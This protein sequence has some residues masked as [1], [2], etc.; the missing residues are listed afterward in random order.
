MKN[1]DRLSKDLMATT[2]E[3]KARERMRTYE[4]EATPDFVPAD[5]EICEQELKNVGLCEAGAD[6][7]RS[8]PTTVAAIRSAKEGKVT[9]VNFDVL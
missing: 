3:E 5:N 6:L 2:T 4:A 8:N 1:L 7:P 9:P